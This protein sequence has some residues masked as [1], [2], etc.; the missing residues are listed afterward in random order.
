MQCRLAG[1]HFFVQLLMWKQTKS[2]IS[3][4][5]CVNQFAGTVQSAPCPRPCFKGYMEVPLTNFLW[6]V[7]AFLRCDN[8]IGFL[9]TVYFIV[10]HAANG[11]PDPAPTL[12]NNF[13]DVILAAVIVPRLGTHFTTRFG[14]ARM[15]EW[16]LIS[17]KHSII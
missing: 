6:S 16:I 12:T 13:S 9:S 10:E 8:A 17:P 15:G 3:S 7:A 1:S 14:S 5:L 11:S 4:Q 2:Q